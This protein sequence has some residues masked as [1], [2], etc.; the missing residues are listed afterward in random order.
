M[1]NKRSL[2]MS[3]MRAKSRISNICHDTDYMMTNPGPLPMPIY[4]PSTTS[5]HDKHDLA[6]LEHLI[7][8]TTGEDEPNDLKPQI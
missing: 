8:N 6:D 3:G 5:S 1:K 2:V 7:V 4:L